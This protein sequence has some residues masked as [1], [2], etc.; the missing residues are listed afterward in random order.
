MSERKEWLE[1]QR[2]SLPVGVDNYLD[3]PNDGRPDLFQCFE[4][5]YHF[6]CC[7]CINVGGDASRCEGCRHYVN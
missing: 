3:P 1:L 6:P 2:K 4:T 5:T 7:I